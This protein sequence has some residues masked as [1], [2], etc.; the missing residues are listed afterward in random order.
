[1]TVTLDEMPAQLADCKK[2]PLWGKH[3]INIVF[4]GPNLPARVMICAVRS[5][6]KNRTGTTS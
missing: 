6:G 3:R 2:C 1:M 5:P 4:G